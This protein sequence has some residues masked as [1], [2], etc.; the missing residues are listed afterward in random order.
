VVR[1]RDD[2]GRTRDDGERRLEEA[3]GLA[4]A[5]NLEV[6]GRES[7]RVDRPRPATLFTSG[8][9]EEIGQAV[10]DLEAPLVLVDGPL[11]PVQ[12]RNLEKAWDAK[13]IDR[14][15]LIL[16]IFGARARTRPS[17]RRF[18]SPL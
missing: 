1:A 10:E 7:R 14:T 2:D 8:V 9:V 12:Q 16:E 18:S 3:C 17:P 4:E 11:S 13:V 6:L 5:I 15:G